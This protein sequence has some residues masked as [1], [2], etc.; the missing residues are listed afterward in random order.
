MYLKGDGPHQIVMIV[1]GCIWFSYIT[2]LHKMRHL[3]PIAMISHTTRILFATL[4]TTVQVQC[5]LAITRNTCDSIS[6]L[7]SL[8]LFV[9][10]KLVRLV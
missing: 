5:D 9:K 1:R 8:N 2:T 6:L 3:C 10:I 7:N 4:D